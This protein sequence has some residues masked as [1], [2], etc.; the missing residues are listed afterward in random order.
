MPD[1]APGRA[2]PEGEPLLELEECVPIQFEP[3]SISSTG[4][5]LAKIRF[6]CRAL[7]IIDK[8]LGI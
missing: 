4:T 5:T 7:Q 6:T 1:A 8:I 3:P 2:R